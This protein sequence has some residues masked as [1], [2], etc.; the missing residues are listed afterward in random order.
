VSDLQTRPMSQPEFDEFCSRLAREYA[1]DHVRA[2]N[3]RSE[4]AEERATRELEELLPEG[5]HTPGALLLV[6]EDAAGEPV[7]LIWVAIE[8][9]PG[10]GGGAWIYDIE[11]REP[12]RG[13][14]YGRALLQAAEREA[15]RRGAPAIGLNVF[16]ANT[17]A[18]GLYESAG[19]EV[20]AQQMRKP[21]V[22][23][24]E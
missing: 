3:W 10:S 21:L 20:T 17:V 22:A 5:L 19:Y 9:R 13:K 14:G 1:A 4:D 7:G 24:D 11:V 2:G 6:A 23:T 18:R 12:H 15:A 16:G 8:G